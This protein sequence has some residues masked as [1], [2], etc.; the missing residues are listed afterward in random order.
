MTKTIL[1]TTL[2]AVATLLTTA[3]DDI[4]F[5]DPWDTTSIQVTAEEG[6]TEPNGPASKG[7]VPAEATPVIRFHWDGFVAQEVRVERCLYDC[8]N[9][10]EDFCWNK[11]DD[12]IEEAILPRQARNEDVGCGWAVGAC[13]SF[14]DCDPSSTGVDYEQMIASSLDYGVTP[15]QW[16]VEQ[17]L[18]ATPLE[19]GGTYAVGVYG[20]DC[21]EGEPCKEVYGCRMFRMRGG[22]PQLM[23]GTSD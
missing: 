6:T 19:E 16:F 2:G 9:Q 11:P 1:C 12:Y 18:E 13:S 5:G 15:P 4:H 20:F 17:D 3:C 7:A 21:S 22:K 8:E 14:A 10:P 23:Q